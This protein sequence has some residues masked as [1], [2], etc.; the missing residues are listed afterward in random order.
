MSDT[1]ERYDENLPVDE[2]WYKEQI[3]KT[4]AF[5]VWVTLEELVDIMG[6]AELNELMD[7]RIGVTLMDINYQVLRI[8]PLEDVVANDIKLLVTGEVAEN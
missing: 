6:L 7:E 3:G 5:T 1:I 2:D 4:V 8:E